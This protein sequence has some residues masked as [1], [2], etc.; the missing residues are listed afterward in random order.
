[1][2]EQK[3]RP[4][5]SLD[6][7][8]RSLPPVIKGMQESGTTELTVET[9]QLSLYVRRRLPTGSVRPILQEAS[10]QPVEPEQQ[11]PYEDKTRYYRLTSP[12]LGEFYRR[13]DPQSEPYVE[14][15]HFVEEGKVL[16]V[17]TANKTINEIT[18]ERAGQVLRIVAQ[19][20]QLMDKGE[21]LVILDTS[22]PPPAPPSPYV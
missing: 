1:M 15:G 16:C 19:N 7:L 22:Q 12:L 5:G 20:E 14:E 2:G 21:V 6:V 3:E 8:V 11:D 17:I 18:T 4:E 10:P 13:P 9:L